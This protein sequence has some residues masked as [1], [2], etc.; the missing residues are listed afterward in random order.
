M[1]CIP[2]IEEFPNISRHLEG[3]HTARSSTLPGAKSP[4]L[5]EG[6]PSEGA[7][8]SPHIW[9]TIYRYRIFLLMLLT[10]EVVAYY[11]WY[12]KRDNERA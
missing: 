5:E 8:K 6:A 12:T 1:I 10:L 3:K 4:D 9:A 2:C 7:T 11:W